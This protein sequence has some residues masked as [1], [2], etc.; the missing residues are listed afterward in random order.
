MSKVKYPIFF[1]AMVLEGKKKLNLR[2][3]EIKQKPSKNQVL[4][5]MIYSGICGKQ[6]EEFTFKMGKDKLSIFD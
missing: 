4:V 3:V 5:K 1:K 2:E 6:V